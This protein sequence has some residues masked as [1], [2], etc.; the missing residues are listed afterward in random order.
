MMIQTD[1]STQGSGAYCN[2]IST[3]GKWFKQEGMWH[4]NVLE[5]LAIKFCT[6]DLYQGKIK[7]CNSLSGG[8]QGCFSILTQDGGT[9]SS[10]LLNI[11]KEIWK[12]LLDKQITITAEYLPSKLNIRADWESRNCRDMSDWKLDWRIF[13]KITRVRGF[14][15]IDLFASRLCHQLPQYISWKPD[16]ISIG[17]DAFQQPWNQK[18]CY[19]FPPFSLITRVLNKVSQ[20]KVTEMLVVTPT[21][22]TQPWYPRLLEMYIQHPL[23]LPTKKNLLKISQGEN[24]PLIKNRSLKLTVLESFR[25]QLQMSGISGETAKPISHSRRPGSI[26]NY[27]STWHKWSSWC[28]E[29]KFDPFRAPVESVIDFLK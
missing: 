23:L 1:A 27:E 24:H 26:S 17:T 22:K 15:E 11:S 10:Q 4:I 21:W 7:S 3:E 6:P 28:R 29:R 14:P 5:L 18:L 2:S 25:S 9:H 13:Q 12:Y 19:A 16:P 8:Q 20:E